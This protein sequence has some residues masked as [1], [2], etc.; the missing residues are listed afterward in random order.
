M[1]KVRIIGFILAL[2]LVLSF[3]GGCVKDQE[4][5]IV[6]N[7][8]LIQNEPENNIGEENED[9]GQDSLVKVEDMF[10]NIVEIDGQV[11]KIVSLAP[12]N[13]ETLFALGLGDKVVGVTSNC[14]YPEEA[15]TKEVVGDYSGNNLERI[16]ELEPD[17][18]LV[19]GP[20]AEE[21]NE[22]LRK[23]GIQVLGFMSET[24]D[25]VIN[26][27]EIIGKVTNRVNEAEILIKS[28]NDKKDFVVN[29][30][31]DKEGKR[32]FYEIWHD[33]LMGAGKGSFMD[34]LITI[35][36][37]KNIAE[38]SEGPYPQ[39]DLEQLI[40]RNPQV[41][42]LSQ[43]SPE[44]TAE[45]VAARPGYDAIDGVKNGYIHLFVGEEAD[46]V[47]RPGPRIGDALILVAKAIYPE[48]F[49]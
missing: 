12:S 30:I 21:E 36:G 26:D 1:K 25:G 13:T 49:K 24:I 39:Y 23:A 10:G 27:I 48:I 44:K 43:D 7:D 17:L 16:V 37:G 47:S 35:S 41:Y 34:E 14:N 3:A 22:I 8:G 15:L 33:P 4:E 32:V 40:E 19:Y 28:I 5:D 20:G 11:S 45:S 42:M 18:V 2:V 6:N 38:D 46:M 31:K 9:K 29:S